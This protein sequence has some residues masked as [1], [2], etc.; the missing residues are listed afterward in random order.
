MA[1]CLCYCCD[2]FWPGD[3]GKYRVGMCGPCH[4]GTAAAYHWCCEK[5]I[6]DEKD[7]LLL[8]GYI[9]GSSHHTRDCQALMARS[10]DDGNPFRISHMEGKYA[11]NLL[12]T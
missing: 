8:V 6:E 3:D 12:P 2:G 5:A 10:Y 4:G 11:F 7:A 1:G 9:H